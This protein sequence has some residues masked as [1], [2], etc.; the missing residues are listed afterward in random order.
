MG[1]F[2]RWFV[3]TDDEVSALWTVENSRAR[4]AEFN[5]FDEGIVSEGLAESLT[6]LARI[7]VSRGAAIF[8][9]FE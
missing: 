1:I 8:G 9:T 7:A 6:K 5:R 4:G 3:A 2:G